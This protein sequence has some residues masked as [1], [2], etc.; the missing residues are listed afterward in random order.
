ML[1]QEYKED[2]NYYQILLVIQFLQITKIT[3]CYKEDT[4]LH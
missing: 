4:N 2:S 3:N 1:L